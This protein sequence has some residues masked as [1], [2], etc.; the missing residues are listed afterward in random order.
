M[1]KEDF[2]V[3]NVVFSTD[4]IHVTRKYDEHDF[5]DNKQISYKDIRPYLVGLCMSRMEHCKTE[6]EAN[7]T[8][9]TY[10]NVDGEVCWRGGHF[11]LP[12]YQALDEF[13]KANGSETALNGLIIQQCIRELYRIAR[14]YK[15]IPCIDEVTTKLSAPEL[16]NI[17]TE[18][19]LVNMAKTEFNVL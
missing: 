9:A 5:C 19:A 16:F 1:N 11:S 8:K 2:S 12:V 4:G 14:E 3:G 18:I 17:V 10:A 6:L 7:I 15:P 13:V